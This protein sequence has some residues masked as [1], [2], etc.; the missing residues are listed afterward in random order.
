[1]SASPYD[2]GLPVPALLTPESALSNGADF[3]SVARSPIISLA[4]PQRMQSMLVMSQL[5]KERMEIR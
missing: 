2:M 4:P 1:M 5:S 3:G